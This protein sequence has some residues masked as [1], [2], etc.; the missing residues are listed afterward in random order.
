[1]NWEELEKLQTP[2][3]IFDEEALKANFNDF[4]NALHTVWGKNSCVAYSVKTNPFPWVL[5]CAK[6]CGCMAE[7]VS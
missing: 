1:M 5:Q 3:F 7:V 6:S 4:N 2:C